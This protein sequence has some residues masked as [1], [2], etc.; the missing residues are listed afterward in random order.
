[1][2]AINDF[3]C[4][5]SLRSRAVG[6][7]KK[8][9]TFDCCLIEQNAVLWDAHAKKA[10]AERTQAANNNSTLQGTDEPS[11]ERTSNDQWTD[12]G[13]EKECGTEQP[14]PNAAPEGALRTPVFDAVA[15]ILV[16][17]HVLICVVVTSNYGKLLHIKAGALK[18]FDA[19]FSASVSF[20][21]RYDCVAN[22]VFIHWIL[23][24][25]F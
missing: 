22:G 4:L 5:G 3:A 14:A 7:Y 1:M 20:V 18:V 10:G 21:N 15:G 8:L 24:I 17:D 19:F 25:G 12:A 11:D 13:D 23:G 2:S 16:A 6:K 9:A